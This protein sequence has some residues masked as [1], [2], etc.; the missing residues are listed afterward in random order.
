[1]THVRRAGSGLGGVFG[2]H[3]VFSVEGAANGRVCTEWKN[4]A[5]GGVGSVFGST[6]VLWLAKKRAANGRVCTR[7]KNEAKIGGRAGEVQNECGLLHRLKNEP[8]L[9]TGVR[10]C[11]FLGVRAVKGRRV[12]ER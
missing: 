10:L 5:I 8:K 4:E 6:Q 12:R 9:C 2:R 3:A 11:A 7:M 1:M